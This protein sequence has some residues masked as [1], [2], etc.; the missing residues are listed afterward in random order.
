M[1]KIKVLYLDN[2]EENL[3]TF[4]NTFSEFFNVQ[5]AMSENDAN[6]ELHN[7]KSLIVLEHKNETSQK[8]LNLKTF[9]LKHK[10]HLCILITSSCNL[11]ILD[12]AVEQGLIYKYVVKPYNVQE[13]V[14]VIEEGYTYFKLKQK[15]K[16]LRK[17]LHATN[18][19]IMKLLKEKIQK[20]D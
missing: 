7:G 5:I 13:L 16:L 9:A 6:F 15:E 20:S 4:K 19:E 10:N 2:N 12:H 14:S 11:E 18:K 1:Q 17:E 8:N 3:L